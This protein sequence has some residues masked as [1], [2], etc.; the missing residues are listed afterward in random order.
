MP[1]RIVPLDEV[2]EPRRPGQRDPRA[3]DRALTDE[4]PFEQR[5]PGPDERVVLDDDRSRP[6]WLENAT[7]GHAG[8]QVYARSDLGAG[9][10][11]DVRIDHRIGADPCSD[12][13]V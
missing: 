8:G 12:V 7:D 9:P 1:S 11:Q 13:D 6:R 2:V 4:H 10:D 5:A 3:D